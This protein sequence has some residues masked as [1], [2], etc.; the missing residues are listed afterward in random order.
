MRTCDKQSDGSEPRNRQIAIVSNAIYGLNSSGIVILSKFR[1]AMAVAMALWGAEKGFSKPLQAG[2]CIAGQAK[3]Y[4]QNDL[5]QH[6]NISH[7][8]L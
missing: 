2:Y 3:G 6:T 1:A 5:L 8:H 7:T 4:L